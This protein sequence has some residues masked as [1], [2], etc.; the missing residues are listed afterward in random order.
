MEMRFSVRVTRGLFFSSALR[1]SRVKGKKLTSGTQGNSQLGKLEFDIGVQ[2]SQF[3][4]D[5]LHHLDFETP[6]KVYGL[7]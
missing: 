7:L 4:L 3:K 2:V 1:A 6:L 5:G